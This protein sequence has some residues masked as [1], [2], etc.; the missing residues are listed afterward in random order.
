[1]SHD[2]DT[3]DN[4]R[5]APA[6]TVPAALL[7]SHTSPTETA[8]VRSTTYGRDETTL[9]RGESVVAAVMSQRIVNEAE[10]ERLKAVQA[11]TDSDAEQA[12]DGAGTIAS[13]NQD[14]TINEWLGDVDMHGNMVLGLGA[15]VNDLTDGAV[16]EADVSCGLR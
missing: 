6:P 5:R 16:A 13:S 9:E 8:H 2:L 14:S 3:L 11:N 15:W 7:R 12:N 1:M 4:A 10:D